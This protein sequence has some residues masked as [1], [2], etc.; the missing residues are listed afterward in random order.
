MI[1]QFFEIQELRLSSVSI[2]QE[3]LKAERS[4]TN[5]FDH[6]GRVVLLESC[7]YFYFIFETESCVNFF[8][9]KDGRFSCLVTVF[10]RSEA[11]SISRC[12]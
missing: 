12:S 5:E 9:L 3:I 1:I 8:Y 10:F 11:S 7:V 6:L 2:K 4:Y